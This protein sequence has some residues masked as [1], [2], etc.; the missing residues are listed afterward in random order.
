MS[1]LYYF[2]V[3]VLFFAVVFFLEGGYLVWNAYKG[4]EARRI[5]RRLQAISAVAN[6]QTALRKKRLLSTLPRLERVLLQIP[7]IA[8]LDRVIV[9]SGLNLTVARLLGLML[10]SMLAG[11]VLALLLNLPNGVVPLM[12]MAA[13]AVP[14]LYVRTVRR[15]RSEQIEQQLPEALD[16]IGR[17]LRAGHAFSGA[18]YMVGTEM[19][20]PIANEFHMVSDEIG[21]GIPAQEAMTNLAS[22]VPS[23]DVRYFVVAVLIQHET[24]G[25]MAELL[26]N[27]SRLIRERMKLVASVRVLSAEGRLSAWILTL[28][29]FVIGLV[30]QQVNP[31]FLSVLWTD[32]MGMRMVGVALTLMGLGILIMWRV[33]KIRI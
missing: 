2:Y 24:G 18:L 20:G 27:I 32:P 25:N 3:L 29:P 10:F 16:L 31:T 15:K 13:V 9:Q 28:L 4:P 21:Y 19:T 26:G 5:E 33:I 14:V 12:A 8:L 1:F 23:G 22:R 30:L 6:P 7:R 11:T 17:A